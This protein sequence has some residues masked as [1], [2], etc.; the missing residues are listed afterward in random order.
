MRFALLHGGEI[1]SV[2]TMLVVGAVVLGLW[3]GF[4]QGRSGGAGSDSNQNTGD[5]E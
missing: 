4:R 1:A 3:L 5:K 2:L